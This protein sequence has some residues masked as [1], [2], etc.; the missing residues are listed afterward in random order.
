MPKHDFAKTTDELVREEI[1]ERRFKAKQNAKNARL[2]WFLL[3]CF[4][5]LAVII[6]VL[7]A[8]VMYY[9]QASGF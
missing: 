1:F 6:A 5:G 9:R 8:T 7:V 4:G 3:F 2:I